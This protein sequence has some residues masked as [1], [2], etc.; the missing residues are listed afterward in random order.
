MNDAEREYMD[1]QGEQQMRSSAQQMGLQVAAEHKERTVHN[2]DFLNELRKADLDSETYGWLEEEYPEWFSGA[3]AVTNRGDDWGMQADLIMQN[4]RERA[5][6]EGRPGRLLR[7]RPFMLASMRGDESPGLDAYMSGDIPGSR[8]YWLEIVARSQT[9]QE[10]ISSEEMSRIYGA[11]DV[12]ADL[13]TLS[14]NAAGLESV[15][16]VKTETNVRKQEEDESTASRVGRV[17]E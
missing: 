1:A 9:T 4:K 12:A 17:L 5:V 14:R 3:H 6:A 15:S 7:D 2:E 16:T 11:A 13:M 8:D 10:P